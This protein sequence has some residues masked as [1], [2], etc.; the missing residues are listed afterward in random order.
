MSKYRLTITCL[1]HVILLSCVLLFHIRAPWTSAFVQRALLACAQL[2]CTSVTVGFFVILHTSTT[3]DT[4]TCKYIYPQCWTIDLR[5]IWIYSRGMCN[6]LLRFYTAPT[7]SKQ[8]W[9]TQMNILSILFK[10]TGVL[11]IFVIYMIHLYTNSCN[12][13]MISWNP[14]INPLQY[15]ICFVNGLLLFCVAVR[16]C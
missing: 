2:R 7:H 13:S 15:T 3:Y 10:Q 8:I 9:I 5:L 1:L 4:R 11:H 14:L 6:E 12:L 16:W